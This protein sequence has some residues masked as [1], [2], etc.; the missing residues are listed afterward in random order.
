MSNS[1]SSPV[2]KLARMTHAA[3]SRKKLLLMIAY[4]DE[5]GKPEDKP[6]VSLS[7]VVSSHL[8]WRRFEVSWR[9]LLEE[10]R[11]PINST[12]QLRYF[13]MTDYE[14]CQALPYKNWKKQKRI[15]F[16]AKLASLIKRDIIFGC[17]H[18]LVVKD[19]NE[20]VGPHIPTKFRKNQGWYMFLLQSCLQD[21]ARSV[22]VK[23]HEDIA[24]VMDT[25]QEAAPAAISFYE[26]LKK[27]KGWERRFGAIA[28]DSSVKLCPLQA[29]DMLAFE[30]ADMFTIKS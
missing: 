5:S 12:F 18:S 23:K 26:G 24:C 15:E 25:N 13:H 28:Y 10:Y 20:T 21:I 2:L 22:L 19:W 11:A 3:S 16:A 7:A 30:G 4:F 17:V 14:T 27:E 9:K 8:K 1:A 29:A 6:I